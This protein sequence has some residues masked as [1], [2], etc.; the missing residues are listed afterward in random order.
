MFYK[1]SFTI[2]LLF[3]IGSPFGQVIHLEE[4]KPTLV[5]GIEYGYLINNEQSKSAGGEE[6]SRF[7]IML[8]ATNQSGCTK[9]YSDNSVYRS[10]DVLNTIAVY[11]CTNANGKRL[12]SKS[13][14]VKVRDFNLPVKTKVD[15]KEI[16]Q[17]IKAGY[18]FFNGETLKTNIIV[19][20][21]KGTLP[22]INCTLNNLPEM[23]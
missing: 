19:L 20:V 13:G 2:I 22:V 17:T 14:S 9:L 4:N 5:N 16:V 12:T 10:S 7:E 23:R 18:I 3:V 1:T 21:P 8:Y 11:N 6:Y 15:G